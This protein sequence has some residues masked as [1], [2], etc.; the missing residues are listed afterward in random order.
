MML[1]DFADN[2]WHIGFAGAVELA[3]HYPESELLLIHW[4]CV[5]APN[6]TPFNGDP[7]RLEAAVTN[8]GRVHALALGEG[9]AL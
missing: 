9:L 6:Y 8:P 3:N 1:F 7:E 2:I 5:D 4:G